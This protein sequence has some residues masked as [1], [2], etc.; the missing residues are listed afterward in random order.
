[1]RRLLVLLPLLLL[2]SGCK[3]GPNYTRPDVPPPAVG[4]FQTTV[5]GTD[6]A[7]P[8]RP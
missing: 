5:A 6:A 8:V 3:V 2:A 4:A 1:M 7:T